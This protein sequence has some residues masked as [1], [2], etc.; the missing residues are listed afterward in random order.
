MEK[1]D[2]FNILSITRL[3]FDPNVHGLQHLTLHTW[4]A[5]TVHIAIITISTATA[6]DRPYTLTSIVAILSS[7]LPLAA[8]THNKMIELVF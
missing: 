6:A 4:H 2:D 7:A 5:Y 8:I 1:I 3:L